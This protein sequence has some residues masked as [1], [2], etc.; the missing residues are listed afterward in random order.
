MT[1]MTVRQVLL[2]AVT[3]A[4]TAIAIMAG[5]AW[6]TDH[7]PLLIAAPTPLVQLAMA[8]TDLTLFTS[9]V[10]AVA[11]TDRSIVVANYAN[12]FIVD[13]DSGNGCRIAPRFSEALQATASIYVPTGVARD[14]N[15]LFVANYTGNNVLVGT[16]DPDRCAITFD[17]S[18]SHADMRSPESVAID[19]GADLLIAANYDSDNV[20]AFRLSTGMHLWSTAMPNAHGV[21]IGPTHAYATSLGTRQLHQ[22]DRATGRIVHSIGRLGSSRGRVEFAWPTSVAMMPDGALVVADAHTG[23]VSLHSPDRLSR[24]FHFGSNGPAHS[25][26]AMPYAAIPIGKRL[27]VLSTFANAIH[28]IDVAAHRLSHVVTPA[29]AS[30]SRPLPDANRVFETSWRGYQ[31]IDGVEVATTNNAFVP[32]YGFLLVKLPD[33]QGKRAR[34]ELPKPPSP[35]NRA[36]VHYFIDA[37]PIADIGAVVFSLNNPVGM[38]VSPR[39]D[40]VVPV[41]IGINCWRLAGE[42]ECPDGRRDRHAIGRVLQERRGRV[43]ALLA[44][45]RADDRI[46]I[47]ELIRVM[48][49]EAQGEPIN[50]QAAFSTSEG[51]SFAAIAAVCEPRCRPGD[52]RA[53]L[54]PTIKLRFATR[55]MDERALLTVL[56][57]L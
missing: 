18:I 43:A 36:G 40:I 27:I 20:Q 5:L 8:P 44:Q 34:L 53:A 42:I 19:P 23:H 48:L 45:A 41:V 28:V 6:R 3:I 25:N 7:R 1:L 11:L 54:G 9:P 32:S 2:A 49:G 39:G 13:I 21:T 33:Q 46:S 24:T 55:P 14:G 50:W 17:R 26:Y 56:A 10:S 35:F 16:L 12:L 52:I 22:L 51:R 30:W 31:R 38:A 15:R 57:E 4:I 29:P 37:V 47:A